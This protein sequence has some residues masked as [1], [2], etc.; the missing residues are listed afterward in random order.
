MEEVTRALFEVVGIY[1]DVAGRPYT[2]D[3]DVITLVLQ[4]Y[5]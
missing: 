2:E 1:S 4:K 3:S 5:K